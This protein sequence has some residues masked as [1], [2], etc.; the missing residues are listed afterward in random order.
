MNAKQAPGGSVR[1]AH[2]PNAESRRDA[3]QTAQAD[4]AAGAARACPD[5]TP[6]SPSQGP[7]AGQRTWD[8]TPVGG[9]SAAT[10]EPA[11][12]SNVT[13]TAP[14]LLPLPQLGAGLLLGL[15]LLLL[16]VHWW[17]LTQAEPEA[18]ELHRAPQNR[19]A[20]RLDVN[21]AT[22]VEWAQLP[23]IGPALAQ[24]IVEY[25]KRHGRFR[26]VEELLKVRGI[27][28]KVLQRMRPYLRVEEPAPTGT[29]TADAQVEPSERP[30]GRG[31]EAGASGGSRR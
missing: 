13:P 11:E 21:S 28:P 27:G 3:S 15:I 26:R 10:G 7:H 31:T 24:R 23:G 25:R 5:T 19:Y 16:V 14:C 12:Q 17:R 29:A 6:G 1:P 20:F 22:W 8:S 30:N 4:V 2:R 9:I 18:V